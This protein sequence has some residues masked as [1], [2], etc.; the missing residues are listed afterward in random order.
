MWKSGRSRAEQHFGKDQKKDDKVIKQKEK[1]ERDRDDR[2]ARLRDQ[3]LA[4]EAEAAAPEPAVPESSVPE[5]SVPESS[6][7]EPSEAPEG[8]GDRPARLPRVHPHRS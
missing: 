6:A 1:A 3:R 4:R 2:M 5:S 8:A 7:P